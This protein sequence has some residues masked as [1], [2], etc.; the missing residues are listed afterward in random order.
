MKIFQDLPDIS[1]RVNDTNPNL[2]ITKELVAIAIKRFQ[3]LTQP[4]L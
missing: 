4:K 3:K 2:V 1:S